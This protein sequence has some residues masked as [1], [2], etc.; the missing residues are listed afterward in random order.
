MAAEPPDLATLLGSAKKHWDAL[1]ELLE[2]EEGV[3]PEWRFYGK[4]HGW[5]LKVSAG[6]R[7]LAYL[8]PRPGRF[9]AAFA[10][11][12]GAIAALRESGFPEE[13]AGEIEAADEAPEGKPARVEVRRARD[14]SL[15]KKLVRAKLG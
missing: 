12:A 7:A 1:L 10:L 3:V 5:Q 11:R 14:L 13:L 6:K 2:G 9:T 4:K 15:V 8:I